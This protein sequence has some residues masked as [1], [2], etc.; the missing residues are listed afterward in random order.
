MENYMELSKRLLAV[1][2]LVTSERK[3]A[4][5]GCDHGYVSIYL[6]AVKKCP[7]V[8]A[9]DVKEGPLSHAR[10]NIQK[11]GLK[12]VIDV[13]LSDG[14]EAL[15]KNE[16][17]TLLI[18]GMGGRLMNRILQEGLTCL[19]FFEE[20]ILQPQTEADA[21]RKFLRENE[22]I[23]VDEDFVTEDGKYYPMIK[24][25]YRNCVNEVILSSQYPDCAHGKEETYSLLQEDLFGPVLLRKRPEDFVSYMKQK[26]ERTEEILQKIT[27]PEKKK[28]MQDYLEQ[29]IIVSKDL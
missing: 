6:A 16:V 23:I 5:I 29:L 28:E 9:M 1:A 11:Y 14:T 3:V 7:K 19:G 2:R 17:D 15:E 8:I 22:Y 27:Q 10:T 25:L 4:D 24:A 26:K 20:L 18:S 12:N 13:R 21:V